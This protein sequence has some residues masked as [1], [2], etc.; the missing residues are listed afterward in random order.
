[1]LRRFREPCAPAVQPRVNG[2]LPPSRNAQTVTMVGNRLF[3]FGGHSGNK[4]LRDLHI[5]D[6]ETMTWTQVGCSPSAT[7]CPCLCPC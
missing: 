1:M 2:T 4:H 6:T 5:L 7:A 3:L